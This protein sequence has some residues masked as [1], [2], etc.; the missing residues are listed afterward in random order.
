MWCSPPPAWHDPCYWSWWEHICCQN[1][2]WKFSGLK[3]TLVRWVPLTFPFFT[4]LFVSRKWTQWKWGFGA[5]QKYLM[6][7]VD[8]CRF[9]SVHL[10]RH[11]FAHL[12]LP[13]QEEDFA[14]GTIWKTS[15]ICLC[16]GP[17]SSHTPDASLRFCSLVLFSIQ[18]EITQKTSLVLNLPGCW[19]WFL[20]LPGFRNRS[21]ASIERKICY[22]TWGRFDEMGWGKCSVSI[23]GGRWTC[24][25]LWKHSNLAEDGRSECFPCRRWKYD[26][27]PSMHSLSRRRPSFGNLS[28]DWHL[29]QSCSGWWGIRHQPWVYL[30]VF[31][32]SFRWL[33]RCGDP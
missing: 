27:Q 11:L 19:W 30:E 29:G 32:E 14:D 10:Q 7:N 13:A 20:H 2:W 28:G 15:T 6:L 9:A 18:Q 8:R 23:G 24:V 33:V 16:W 3:W 26:P 25:G 17:D 22:F 5:C 1:F 21:L 31:V 12:A 4:K